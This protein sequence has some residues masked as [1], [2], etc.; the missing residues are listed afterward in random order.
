MCSKQHLEISNVNFLI[1]K[2]GSWKKMGFVV[3]Y[4][5]RIIEGI[6]IGFSLKLENTTST[7]V[8]SASEF[9]MDSLPAFILKLRHR[10]IK[11]AAAWYQSAPSPL[12]GFTEGYNSRFR[13]QAF[14]YWFVQ[15][16][17]K[18]IIDQF[19]DFVLVNNENE[20]K[21]FRKL[22][23]KKRTVVVL[24]AIDLENIKK[25]KKRFTKKPKI[26][27]A[28]FQGRFHP[29]KG[30]VELIDIWKKVIKR[31]ADAKL[32]LIGNGPLMKRVEEKVKGE[33]LEKN[34][35]LEGYLF[36]GKEKYKIFSQSKL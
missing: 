8:Y 35:F 26:Y 28:V 18:P 13:L 32:M 21:V 30:V 6:R 16:P 5:A 23:K 29:Q 20:K 15:L 33:K 22:N 12:T 14:I 31:T 25:W 3:N 17:I 7:I 10:Q 27:D 36:D 2:M 11:W 9:W 34:I 19:A 4:I 24:G 1:S